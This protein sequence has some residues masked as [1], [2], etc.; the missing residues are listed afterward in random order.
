MTSILSSFVEGIKNVWTNKFLIG[1]MFVFKLVFSLILLFPLY[2]MFSASFATNVKASNFLTWYDFSLII[3]FI[4]YWRK[5]LSVYFFLFILLGG[6]AVI[7]FIFLSGGFW[8]ILR[9]QIK[10]RTENFGTE[11][12]GTRGEKFFCYCG[13]YFWGMFKIGFFMI[14]LY[15]AALLLFLIF[16]VVFGAVAGKGNLWEITSWRMMVRI[17]IGAI[18]FSLTN[19]IGDYLRI[20]FLENYGERFSKSVKKTFKFVLTNLFGVL[21]LYY[22]LSV[23]LLVVIFL[24]LGL[25]QTIERIP[26]TGFLVLLTFS[27]QQILV[28]FRSFYRLVYYSSQLVFYDKISS[29][30]IGTS[31]LV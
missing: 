13:K 25:S 26:G 4:Y 16:S 2:L 29:K 21:I 22:I 3:D 19:M 1:I 20:F 24:N 18:L 12:S 28:A 23:I 7:V 30:D 15:L 10:K 14:V 31:Q 8:G 6:I 11:Q 17:L 9:D 27:I 5:T